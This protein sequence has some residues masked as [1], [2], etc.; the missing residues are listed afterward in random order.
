MNA[1]RI[2]AGLVLTACLVAGI[3][4]GPVSAQSGN[5]K[6]DQEFD[7]LKGAYQD[8]VD[9]LTMPKLIKPV[10]PK[11]TS[12]AMRAKIQGMVKVQIVVM[13]DGTVGRARVLDS[14]DPRFGLDANALAAAKQYRF[15]AGQLNGRAVPVAVSIDLEFR[16]H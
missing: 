2:G 14:L 5:Q 10:L 11:Y 4:A 3:I 13:E 1:S 6:Q 15:E 12:D 16:L 9:G 7:F 8:G